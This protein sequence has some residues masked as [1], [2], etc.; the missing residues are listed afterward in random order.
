MERE[1][2]PL[3]IFKDSFQIKAYKIKKEVLRTILSIL[4]VIYGFVVV[5]RRYIYENEIFVRKKRLPK[6]VIS[7]GNLSVGG[8]GKTPVVIETAK[9]L[10]EK[11][12]N[13]VVLSRGY[14]RKSKGTLIVSN[15]KNIFVSWEEAG[16]EPYLIASYG[17][18]VVVSS[19]RYKAGKHALKHLPVDIFLLD[20]G[21]QHYQ[22]DRDIDVVLVDATRPFWE[23]DLLPLGRLREPISVALNYID[24][25]ILTKTYTLSNI[26][27]KRISYHLSKYFKPV[28]IAEEQF[29]RLTNFKD[30]FPIDILKDKNIGLFAGLGNNKQFFDAVSKLAKEY[31][32]N[33][34]AYKE[35][36]DHY[37]YR[38][39]SLPD[40]D[41]D[42]WI[43]T[44]KDFIKLPNTDKIL[45]LKYE[46]KLPD[47]YIREITHR[48]NL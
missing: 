19:S 45:A 3:E 38:K 41:V 37:D 33:I 28:F 8:T 11:G 21:F 20:D 26:E 44:E 18:P 15:G 5:L 32:F 46:I 39:F 40:V 48:L 42:F 1:N 13:V 23:D 16:D 30:D 31:N 22:L 47:K 10:Q 7:I 43:T 25:F 29:N 35:F 17:I 14:K 12:F 2:S 27:K 9:R 36:P 34:K 24:M 4:A 6:P